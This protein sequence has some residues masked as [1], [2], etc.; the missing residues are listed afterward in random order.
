MR[1]SVPL[2]NSSNGSGGDR[3]QRLAAGLPARHEAA[4]RLAPLEQIAGFDAVFGRPVERRLGDVRVGNRDPE[5]RAE[6][7]QLVFVHLLLLVGDV[8]ALARLAETV[9]LDRPGQ[10]DRRRALEVDGGFVGVVHLDRIVPAQRHL[11][12]LVIREVLDHVEQARIDAPEMFADV[13]ARF[14]GVFLILPVDDLAHPSHQETVTIL[15]EQ[16]IPLASPD[17]LD[18]VP[19]GATK[20]GFQLLNDLAVAAHRTVE[21]LEVAVDDEDQV[22]QLFARRQ[23][24]RAQGFGLVGFAVAEKRPDLAVRLRLEAAILEIPRE[25]RLVD[26]HQRTEAH[27]HRGVF[28]EIGHQPGMG[29]RRQPAARIQLAAEIRQV[30][31]VDPSFQERPGVDTGRRV[32]LKVDDVAVVAVVSAEE[33]VEADFVERGGRRERRDMTADALVRLVRF[34]HHRGGIPADQ[35]LDAALD[36]RTAGH[37]HLVVGG[38]RVEVRSV[39]GERQLD[40]VLGGVDGQV[41]QQPRDFGG[42][43]GLQHIIEGLEPFVRFNG[44]ELRRIFR[45]NVSH[46]PKFLS[47]DSER[48]ALS[49]STSLATAMSLSTCRLIDPPAVSQPLIVICWREGG[50]ACAGQL[51][52]S[53]F[54]AFPRRRRSP[55]VRRAAAVDR[56]RRR[57]ATADT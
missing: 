57:S 12:E 51:Y 7:P 39:G 50:K 23:G 45:S 56:G 54:V 48:V 8:L 22:V 29:I 13:G 55:H 19:T 20:R 30:R 15:G 6:R 42:P 17:H 27:R 5:P 26:R 24:D 10:N 2:W 40:A 16:R 3:R 21:A 9:A 43:A 1:P 33:M 41:A 36:V 53:I 52:A 31:L 14:D 44:I 35:A 11:L 38:N 47:S 25:A 37:R 49:C 32:T 34:D 18:H 4:E 46:G 28:P